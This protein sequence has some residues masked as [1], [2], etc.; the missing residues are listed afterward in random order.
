MLSITVAVTNTRP[1]SDELVTKS[2]PSNSRHAELRSRFHRANPGSCC[3][4]ITVPRFGRAVQPAGNGNAPLPLGAESSDGAQGDRRP[5]VN[6]VIDCSADEMVADDVSSIVLPIERMPVEDLPVR[7]IV[8]L[9]N[10]IVDKSTRD[11][12]HV[13]APLRHGGQRVFHEQLEGVVAGQADLLR[14]LIPLAG[15][16][17]VGR[18][19]GVDS[20]ENRDHHPRP[21]RDG[22]RRRSQVGENEQPAVGRDR[23]RSSLEENAIAALRQ[24][25]FRIV[26]AAE[27]A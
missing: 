23:A 22:K 21:R 16:A 1:V 15:Q 20:G 12:D 24:N 27:L 13:V 10:G 11:L 3:P 6:I 2:L 26:D 8:L 14:D 19:V 25:H 17:H 5:G 7:S 9:T 18:A 4:S